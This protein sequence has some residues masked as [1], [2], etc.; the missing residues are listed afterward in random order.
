V[1]G[2]L[3]DD[4]QLAGMLLRGPHEHLDERH[5]W[6]PETLILSPFDGKRGTDRRGAE[7]AETSQSR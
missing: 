2:R 6:P 7:D 4:G 3:V 1:A 5:G